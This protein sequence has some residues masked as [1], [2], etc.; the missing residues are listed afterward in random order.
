[1]FRVQA[2][3]Q[4]AKE[5]L[6]QLRAESDVYDFWTE[7]ALGR[8]T[9]IMT[10][11]GR[12]TNDLMAMLKAHDISYSVKIDDVQR[13]IETNRNAAS[14][15]RQPRSGRY[16]HNWTS[17]SRAAVI[18]EFMFEMARD[19]PELVTVSS[20]GKTHLGNDM[21]MM[22]ISSGGSGKKAMFVDGGIHAREWISPA[23][24]TWFMMHLVENQASH[25]QLLAEL[26]WYFVP[27]INVDGYEYSHTNNRL[28]RKNRKPTSTGTCVGI[29]LN[30]N[31]GF[32]WGEG[33]TSN[34]GCSEIYRG[35]SAFSE[36]ESQ[37]LRDVMATVANQTKCYL[38]FHSYGQDALIPW[39]YDSP[40]ELPP[41]FDEMYDLA[42]SAT[43][44]LTNVYGTRY[45]VS[46]SYESYGATAGSS[47]DWAIGGAG[48]KYAYTIE[49]RDQGQYGF[50]LPASQIIPTAE[51]TWELVKVMA[52]AMINEE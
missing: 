40:N 35:T 8:S 49:L 52:T 11:P 42:V 36:V 7:P 6:G 48:I 43:Q 3:S 1:M 21:Y 41:F 10:P 37:N 15:P 14:V 27:L 39:S 32:H 33:G 16:S 46:N 31:F 17:Y 38:T 44:A 51:E 2:H 29:D 26:D 45:G 12:A 23:V 34:N 30:R 9:D 50:E 18:E 20:F 5:A 25:P 28:W 47:D 4:A 22:K 13:L 24:V 19:H